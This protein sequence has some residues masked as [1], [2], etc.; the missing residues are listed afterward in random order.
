MPGVVTA[1]AAWVLDPVVCAGM[2]TIGAPR[3]AVSALLDLHH[4]LIERGFRRSSRDDP[5]GVGDADWARSTAAQLLQLSPDVIIA[6]TTQALDPLLQATRTILI[7]FIG[8]SDPVAQ[9]FV[10]SLAHPGGNS[11]GF[12]V[13]EPSLGGKLLGLLKEVVP[14]L[15]RIAVLFNPEVSGIGPFIDSGIRAAPALSVDLVL[16]PAREP[17]EIEPAIARFEREP[18]CGLLVP[19]DTL[20]NTHRKLIIELAARY[21]LPAIHSFRI[22]TE[23]GALLSYGVDLPELFRKA[24]QYADRIL[25]GE[26]PGDLPVQQPTKFELAINLKTAKSLGLEVPPALLAAA[27]EVIE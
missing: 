19:P 13:L 8:P 25:R 6:N 23:D 14:R 20:M 27:A 9:G 16:A 17:A 5:N 26:K 21:R 18:N 1:I 24:A 22:A 12:I 11:T 2:A 10:Q 3:I 4:L 15:N 7:V